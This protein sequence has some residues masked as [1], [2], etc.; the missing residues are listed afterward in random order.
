MFYKKSKI[1][2]LKKIN[3]S[4]YL[5]NLP[6]NVHTDYDLCSYAVIKLLSYESLDEFT[7]EAWTIA[8]IYIKK[9]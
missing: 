3:T 8:R 2:K 1:P 5:F 6:Q 7:P 4:L 9:S